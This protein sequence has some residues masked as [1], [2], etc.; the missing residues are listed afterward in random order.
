MRRMFGI[1]A[2]TSL[3]MLAALA[4]SGVAAASTPAPFF[5]GF[6]TDTH[7][8][9]VFGGQYDATRVV[10]GTHGVASRTGS[11]HAEAGQYD[12]DNQGGSAATDWGGST[13][14]FPANGY[15]TSV[16]VYLNTAGGAA[17]DTRF[18][19]DSAISDT[20]G[21]FR[22]DFLFNGGFY[23]DSD[24]TGSGP[25]FVFTA[26]NNAGRGSS[27]PKNPGRDPFSITTTGW[28]T[29]QHH[30][31]DNGTGVLAV[32]LSI[33]D[34]A[35][36][37]LHTWTLS[38]PTDIIGTTVGGDQYG[39]FASQ[40]FPFLA[41]DNSRLSVQVGP[42]TSKDQCKKDGWKTFNNP[43]FKNQGDCVSYV[44][45]GGRNPGNG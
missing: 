18:D 40:E 44:A 6:E 17:N 28:Y 15:T 24:S 41:F 11:W 5:N 16:D 39:W 9:D 19:W 43:A 4:A 35:G 14:D 30:F 21:G 13:S 38:D 36:N 22:R 37:V 25:R 2:A 42:P 27:F 23:N 1:V 26:S 10:S 33:L 8:W 3:L 45:T 29:F 7:G 12:L 34:A 20:S 31:Y 32:D